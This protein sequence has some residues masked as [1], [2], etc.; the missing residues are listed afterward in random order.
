M[1]S[2]LLPRRKEISHLRKVV[3]RV[4]KLL[5]TGGS[6]YLRGRADAYVISVWGAR[7]TSDRMSIQ[8]DTVFGWSTVAGGERLIDDSGEC[9]YDCPDYDESENELSSGD[10]EALVRTIGL[11]PD[12]FKVREVF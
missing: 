12:K 9:L 7:R 1:S 11:M 4:T 3:G 10:I 5:E 6:V 2:V 8:A